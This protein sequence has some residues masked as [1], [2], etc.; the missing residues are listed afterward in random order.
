M[1]HCQVRDLPAT[2]SP[3]GTHVVSVSDFCVRWCDG[4]R[5]RYSL[6]TG[7]LRLDS[8]GLATVYYKTTEHT[9]GEGFEPSSLTQNWMDHAPP[10]VAAYLLVA[11]RTMHRCMQLSHEFDTRTSSNTTGGLPIVVHEEIHDSGD[12]Q[13]LISKHKVASATS[14]DASESVRTETLEEMRK[15]AD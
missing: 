13:A 14:S 2:F 10:Q 11:Q 12:V 7:A 3:Y 15:I 1:L 8:P 4:T 6:S 5:L 9:A